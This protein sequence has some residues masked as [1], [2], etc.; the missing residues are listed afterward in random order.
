MSSSSPERARTYAG[1]ALHMLSST[2]H[3]PTTRSRYARI[4][5]VHAGVPTPG[6]RSYSHSH[7]PALAPQPQPR[8]PAPHPGSAAP[9]NGA[10]E[11]EKGTVPFVVIL[12]PTYLGVLP[13]TLLPTVGFLVPIVL[14]AAWFVP[15]VTA[16]FE[17]FVRQAREDLKAG[18]T[19]TRKE[20]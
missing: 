18:M 1:A 19:Q 14:A 10:V 6:S 16:Y 20:R 4:R 9:A 17:P 7:S 8:V 11:R 15:W 2:P 5:A 12:E 13:A 3:T